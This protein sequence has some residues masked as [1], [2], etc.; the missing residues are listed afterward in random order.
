[1]SKHEI[2]LRKI[3]RDHWGPDAHWVEHAH[4]GTSG[5]ADCYLN[6]DGTLLPCEL[7]IGSRT[8]KGG[9]K[10]KIQPSQYLYHSKLERKGMHSL[11]IALIEYN[12]KKWALYIFPGAC[13]GM[14][15]RGE[16]IKV[17]QWF[18]GITTILN[19]KTYPIREKIEVALR[20]PG[21][22]DGNFQKGLAEAT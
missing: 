1:M 21:F 22:W 14:I 15:S 4:G 13:I 7:K 18:V 16:W 17:N 8:L 9:L 5:M 6:F 3:I 10:L 20:N 2:E 12:P 19:D 11:F